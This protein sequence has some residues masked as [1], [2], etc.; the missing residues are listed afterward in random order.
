MYFI[1]MILW[2]FVKEIQS[3]IIPVFHRFFWDY[4]L[5]RCAYGMNN[6]KIRAVAGAR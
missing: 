1:R 2:L 3:H 5:S 6:Y 4:A